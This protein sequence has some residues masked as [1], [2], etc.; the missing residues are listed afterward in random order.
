[1][2][3]PEFIAPDF[4]DDNTPE[5]IH[6]R[7]M[8]SLPDDIDDMPGGFPYDFTMPSAIEKS[9]LI[10]FHLVRALMI[11]FP[12]YAWD[13]WLDL[14]GKQVDVTRHEASF[15]RGTL[16][17]KGESRTKIEAG[18]IFCVPAVD[19]TPAVQ[20]ETDQEVIIGEDGVATVGITA[21]EAGPEGN[22]KAGSISIMDDP[23]DEI[24]EITNPE[25]VKGGSEA[26]SDDNYYDRIAVA[27]ESSRTYLGNDNDFKRWAKEAGAGDCIVDDAW[28]GP[29]TVK[30]VLI[31]A[32]GQPADD[33]LVQK[34][35]EHIVSSDDRSARL[36]PTAC[37]SLTCVS[38]T[39]VKIDYLCTGLEY[40]CTTDI[41]QIEEEFR[42]ALKLLYVEAKKKG[43]LR[44]NDVRPILSA[45]VG[46]E[47]FDSF[48]INGS[49]ENISF[50]MEE[51]PE[52][53]K[54]E[55]SQEVDI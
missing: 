54:C 7:M 13:E 3:Q 9:E 38:A 23:V 29:G 36:L 44:Y 46:V 27:Y 39:T 22:V 41:E 5:D 26:E 15:A 40:G 37:A 1:M 42:D 47:D 49:M 52:T 31:D 28:N 45:I 21:V 24:T 35:Y 10:N 32:N 50:D 34:V 51:Y 6:E 19:D 8:E 2:A 55:F 14:H 33:A 18:T 12:Q 4:V 16:Q 17:L 43:V 53:G 25:D 11:A 48:L 20:Y 30:L